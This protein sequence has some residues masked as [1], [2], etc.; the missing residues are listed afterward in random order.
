[1]NA[2]TNLPI[3]FE[4]ASTASPDQIDEELRRYDEHLRDVRGLT[5]ET[6]RSYGGVAGC[7]LHWKFTD[8]AVD[9]S[10]L[11]PA[12]VHQFLASQLDACRT[13]SNA[14]GLES[15]ESATRRS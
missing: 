3:P 13:P 7:L 9:P 12:D 8:G 5:P 1:M 4:R 14:S 6:R 15:N 2:N 11:H 10:K